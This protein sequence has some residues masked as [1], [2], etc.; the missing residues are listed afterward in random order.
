MG[1]R[2]RGPSLKAI[3]VNEAQESLAAAQQGEQYTRLTKNTI[4]FNET[5]TLVLERGETITS[6]NMGILILDL[7]PLTFVCHHC[8]KP[9]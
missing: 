2:A 1:K 3:M 7:W 5:V 9:R 8:M 6:K 4:Q